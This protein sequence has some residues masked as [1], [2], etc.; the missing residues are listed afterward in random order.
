MGEFCIRYNVITYLRIIACLLVLRGHYFSIF[1]MPDIFGK[2]IITGAGPVTIFFVIS[3]FLAYMSLDNQQVQAKDYYLRRIKKLV[4]SYYMILIACII[5]FVITNETMYD[6]MKIGWLRYFSFLNMIIPSFCFDK[7]NNLYGF[8][9]MGCFPV[10][11]LLAPYLY[12]KMQNIKSSIMIFLSAVFGMIIGT[13]IIGYILQT[14]KFDGVNGFISTSPIS[15]LYLFVLGM[16]SAFAYK[17]DHVGKMAVFFGLFLLGMLASGKSG[18]VL[19]GGV[20]SIIVL[21]PSVDLQIEK[22]KFWNMIVC[23]LDRNSFNIYLLHLLISDIC[24][25]VMKSTS[26]FVCIIAFVI[27]LF[28]AE[29]LSRIVKILDIKLKSL[30][31]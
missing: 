25:Y 31:I 20:T 18:Y 17:R 27:V 10:F 19:W 5:F 11:Y 8:W 28:S 21:I 24:I 15:T 22:N 2:I 6:S 12:R 30:K 29:L 9:T 7:W 13:K 1:S 26:F 4:P 3:G 16:M 14:M 23:F